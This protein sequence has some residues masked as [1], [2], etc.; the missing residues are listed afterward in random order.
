MKLVILMLVS[1]V[2]IAKHK[3]IFHCFS[4]NIEVLTCRANSEHVMLLTLQCRQQIPTP[5]WE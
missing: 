3:D 5:N 2:L 1:S 4:K